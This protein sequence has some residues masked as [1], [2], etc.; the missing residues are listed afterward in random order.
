VLKYVKLLI[1]NFKTI[2]LPFE[3]TR[4]NRLLILIGLCVLIFAS[5]KKADDSQ[6]V[7][8]SNQAEIDDKAIQDYITAHGINAKRVENKTPAGVSLGPDTI[9][10]WYQVIKQGPAPTLYNAN[11]TRVTV[12]YTGRLLGGD[13]FTQTGNLH[14]SFLLG[15]VIRGWQVGIPKV[16]KG[17]VVRLFISSRY[18][19]GPYA[20]PALGPKGL[21]ANAVLDFDIE[22]FDVTN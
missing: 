7:I 15:E 22:V 16:Y 2:N 6:V 21:P 13:V 11:S 8:N 20:Q 3:M 10:V 5:C 4:M 1:L 17:G 9:G 14:P 19:Y 12:G 18:A